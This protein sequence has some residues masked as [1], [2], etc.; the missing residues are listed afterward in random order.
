VLRTTAEAPVTTSPATEATALRRTYLDVGAVRIQTYLARSRH[1]WGRRGA[2]AVLAEICRP[3]SVDE[4]SEELSSELGAKIRRNDEAAN[5][6]GVIAVIVEPAGGDTTAAPDS[7]DLAPR[8]AERIAARMSRYLPGLRVEAYVAHGPDYVTARQGAHAGM[9]V[10]EWLSAQLE[11]PP[12]EL[13]SECGQDAAVG[14]IQ[15]VDKTLRVC[16]DCHARR[17]WNRRGG[18]GPTR[19][20]AVVY[21]ETADVGTFTV[22]ARLLDAL[23]VASAVDDFGDLAAL[24][25]HRRRNHLATIAADGNALGAFFAEAKAR[26][27]AQVGDAA[28]AREGIALLRGLSETVAATTWQALVAATREVFDPNNE[29]HP[30]VIPHIAGGDDLLVSVT[31]DRTWPFVLTLL[32]AFGGAHTTSPLAAAAAR[33]GLEAPTLSAGVVI[34][35]AS[36][37]FGQ[38]VTLSAE[39]LEQ[40]KTA[41]AGHGFSV[42]WLDTTWDG[43]RP[44]AG[45]QPL[46]LAELEA[47]K[48]GLD[49]LA[50]L[51]QSAL[52]G[53]QREMDTGDERYAHQRLR[54]R[55]RRQEPEVADAVRDFLDC[56]GDNLLGASWHARECL[57]V[58]R[59]ALSLV[60]WW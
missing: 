60:R 3:D 15:V 11:Y 29:Q 20:P 46:T 33:L 54:S 57:R 38:Q 27:A 2:S 21:R 50:T 9:P 1:L 19:H 37:P 23:D 10:F 28:L 17:T 25:R 58:L 16:A 34:S 44:V 51:P 26:T 32:Q 59:A 12:N 49:R 41:V 35:H 24:S 56:A 7:D 39:L 30:P 14:D 52:H 4:L 36:L 53:L 40:A 18:T 43:S 42:A 8:V 48:P 6:D 22:E 47:W 5:I 13:C 55:L 45:R 31:A